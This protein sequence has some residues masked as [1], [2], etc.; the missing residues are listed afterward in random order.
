MRRTRPFIAL[1]AL[2]PLLLAGCSGG[3]STPAASSSSAAPASSAS[4]PAP[5]TPASALDTAKAVGGADVSTTYALTED[6]DSNNL[7]GRP[8]G[9][10][11]A[12]I[13][14]IPSLDASLCDAA[15]SGVDCGFAVEVWP[16]A[17]AATERGQYIQSMKTG[18]ALGTEYD[19][20]KDGVLLRV[21]GDVKPSLASQLNDRFGG[22]QVT[23]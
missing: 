9:Y 16:N 5:A 10:S 1:V 8:N 2:A 4:T 12:A 18:G 7:L 20:A 17:A 6:N 13:G 21:S 15:K 22:Q 19:Y 23:K 14:V 3:S 11:A